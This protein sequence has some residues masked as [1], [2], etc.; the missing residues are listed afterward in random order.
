MEPDTEPE[1][2]ARRVENPSAVGPA[3]TDVTALPSTAQGSVAIRI[4]GDEF[5]EIAPTAASTADSSTR[6]TP[7]STAAQFCEAAAAVPVSQAGKAKTVPIYTDIDGN[8][9]GKAVFQ[10]CLV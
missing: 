1:L 10:V 5:E 6:D 3:S 8:A 9:A 7:A 2:D 4:S